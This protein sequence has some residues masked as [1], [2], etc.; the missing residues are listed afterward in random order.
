MCTASTVGG[1][2]EGIKS[3]YLVV[4]QTGGSISAGRLAWA[5]DSVY[6]AA[7]VC[8]FTLRCQ[9]PAVSTACTPTGQARTSVRSLPGVLHLASLKAFAAAAGRAGRG[10]VCAA[11]V[12]HER[13]DGHRPPGRGLQVRR[14]WLRRSHELQKHHHTPCCA[15]STHTVCTASIPAYGSITS[16]PHL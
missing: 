10:H 15:S 9:D 2:Q 8:L 3:C 4:I 12:Q 6:R 1:H 13:H 14:P 11:G 7:Q 16:H 5:S